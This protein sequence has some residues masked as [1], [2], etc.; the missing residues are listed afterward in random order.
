MDDEIKIVGYKEAGGLLIGVDL[1]KPGSERTVRG[2]VYRD[3][4]GVALTCISHPPGALE[5]L[6]SWITKRPIGVENDER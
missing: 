4:D 1:A 5:R 6:V 2:V 3:G